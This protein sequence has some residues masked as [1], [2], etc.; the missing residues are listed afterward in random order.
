M[1]GGIQ[2]NGDDGSN[3]KNPYIGLALLPMD[4]VRMQELALWG[5]LAV[6]FITSHPVEA[7]QAV[8]EKIPTG[9]SLVVADNDMRITLRNLQEFIGALNEA[10]HDLRVAQ[11]ESEL[12][13]VGGKSKLH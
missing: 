3:P 4:V 9:L 11:A 2:T 13:I 10:L 1:S 12:E 8:Q 5:M 6:T 7:K